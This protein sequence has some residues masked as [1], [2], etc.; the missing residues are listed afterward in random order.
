MMPEPV[1]CSYTATRAESVNLKASG[2]FIE[3]RVPLLLQR[4]DFAKR[5]GLTRSISVGLK[6]RLL[7]I[8]ATIELHVGLFIFVGRDISPRSTPAILVNC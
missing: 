7:G 4:Y 6:V 2:F 3:L 8:R 1:Y 5:T